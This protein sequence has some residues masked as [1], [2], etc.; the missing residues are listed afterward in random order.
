MAASKLGSLGFVVGKHEVY[1]IPL[2]EV[3]IS[4]LEQ[5]PNY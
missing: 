3:R 4:N 5:N 1:P 2:D